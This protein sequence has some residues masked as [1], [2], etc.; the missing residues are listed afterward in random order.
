MPFAIYRDLWLEASNPAQVAGFYG[1]ALTM[2][3]TP[4]ASGGFELRHQ[5]EARHYPNTPAIYV[6]PGDPG[7][8][9]GFRVQAEFSDA[10]LTHVRT[11]VAS[12]DDD[13]AAPQEQVDQLDCFEISGP[14]GSHVSCFSSGQ[15]TGEVHYELVFEVRE[16]SRMARWWARM[17]G[18]GHESAAGGDYAWVTPVPGAPFESLLFTSTQTPTRRQRARVRV[19]TTDV[20]GLLRLGAAMVS[21]GLPGDLAQQAPRHPT[22]VMATPDGTQFLVVDVSG[23]PTAAR[24]SEP[25]RYVTGPR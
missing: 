20:P 21:A 16:P 4:T 7:T 13:P 15:D 2:Q 9:N 1:R 14:E 24:S 3:V 19:A 22:F 10:A 5:D 17:L 8:L 25:P 6:T 23:S 12:S 11:L 18:S